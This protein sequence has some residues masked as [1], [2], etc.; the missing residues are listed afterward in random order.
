MSRSWDEDAHLPGL[1]PVIDFEPQESHWARYLNTLHLKA[2]GRMVVARPSDRFIDYGCG[3]GRI[4]RWLAPQISEVIGLDTSI[5]MIEVARSRTSE[6]N[7]SYRHIEA[8][9]ADLS[10]R[11]P[12]TRAKRSARPPG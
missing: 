1:S 3:V 2:L 6:D 10:W 4:T 7:V 9:P 5:E 8:S 12:F 11:Y